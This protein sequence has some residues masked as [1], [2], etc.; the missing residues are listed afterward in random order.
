MA[1]ALT[2]SFKATDGKGSVI[3]EN[4]VTR[5]AEM[6][7]TGYSDGSFNTGLSCLVDST[8]YIYCSGSNPVILSGLP[9][10]EHTFTVLQPHSDAVTG[11]SFGWEILE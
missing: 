10:G 6:T 11:S 9:P 8:Y 4:G 2:P 3:E 1:N 5:S 7:I